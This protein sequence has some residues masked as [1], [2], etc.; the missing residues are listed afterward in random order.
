MQSDMRSE[1]GKQVAAR[2]DEALR[3]NQWPSNRQFT[4]DAVKSFMASVARQ[5]LENVLAWI[6][7]GA[8]TAKI[9]MEIF[10]LFDE[11]PAEVTH[12]H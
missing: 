8:D 11:G 5:T 1:L 4:R 12:D 2:F 6:Q 10:R 9:E 7:G 3:Q